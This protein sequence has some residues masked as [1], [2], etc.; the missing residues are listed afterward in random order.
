MLK[1]LATRDWFTSRISAAGLFAGMYVLATRGRECG[2]MRVCAVEGV[3]CYAVLCCAVLPCRCCVT[4]LLVLSCVRLCPCCMPLLCCCARLCV[5][6][7]PSPLPRLSLSFLSSVS[8]IFFSSSFPFFCFFFFFLVCVLLRDCPLPHTAPCMAQ[9]LPCEHRGE[10]GAAV[11]VRRPVRR[12]HPH[13]ASRRLQQPGCLRQGGGAGTHPSRAARPRQRP[14]RGRTGLGAAAGHRQLCAD[15]GGVARDAVRQQP[16]AAGAAAGGRQVLARA[17]VGVQ[18]DHRAL[19]GV[20][21]RRGAVATTGC[22]HGA[23]AGHGERG[24]HQCRDACDRDGAG[25]RCGC[26]RRQGEWREWR[27]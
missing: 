20:W 11:A 4:I 13:G 21:R 26:H 3:H 23:A 25:G 2:C 18:Q 19:Q 10:G 6:S 15:G 1:K 5:P 27:G 16:D 22:L 24:A 12:R 9:L 7:N 17:L 14:V 8:V